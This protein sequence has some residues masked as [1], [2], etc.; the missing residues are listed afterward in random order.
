MNSRLEALLKNGERL[1]VTRKYLS[2]V[3]HELQKE[4]M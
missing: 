1:Y 3:K 4:V 2:I